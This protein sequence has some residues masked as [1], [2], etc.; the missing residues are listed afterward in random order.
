MPPDAWWVT[1]DCI[2]RTHSPH[3]PQ[4][5]AD[6]LYAAT[7]R[8]SGTISSPESSAG[9]QGIATHIMINIICDADIKFVVRTRDDIMRCDE[10]REAGGTRYC[11]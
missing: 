11:D 5:D 7:P 3:L 2:T 10:E 9:P 4:Y 1:E 8:C 6:C